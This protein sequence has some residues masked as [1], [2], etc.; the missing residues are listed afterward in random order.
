MIIRGT[1]ARHYQLVDRT[2]ERQNI[3][4]VKIETYR[5]DLHVKKEYQPM[6]KTY[7]KCLLQHIFT[8]NSP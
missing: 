2:G 8:Y 3:K 5:S 4:T 6:I 7:Y 1:K